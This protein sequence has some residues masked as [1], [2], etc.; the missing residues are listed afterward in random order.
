MKEMDDMVGTLLKKLD[1]L[2]IAD[3][4]I[5]AVIS[6]NGAEVFSWP[7]GRVI[8]HRTPRQSIGFLREPALSAQF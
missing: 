5:I 8:D 7:D 3:N 1:D 4:T 6:D 2:G